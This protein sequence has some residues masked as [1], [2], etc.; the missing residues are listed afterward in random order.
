MLLTGEAEA[1]SSRLA[2]LEAELERQR[3]LVS[4]LEEDL[5]AAEGGGGGGAQRGGSIGLFGTEDGE[6]GEEEGRGGEWD[7]GG[8]G[9]WGE[10][11]LRG[12]VQSK[13]GGNEEGGAFTP[14]LVL[15]LSFLLSLSLTPSLP[16]SLPLATLSR[17]FI[18]D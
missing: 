10:G 15:S 4:R 13:R 8:G 2:E 12:V 11:E 5:V 1:A 7:G 3:A 17:A 16:P 9:G 18:V 6:E 14:H